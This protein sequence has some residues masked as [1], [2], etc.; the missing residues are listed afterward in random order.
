MTNP[1]DA[2]TLEKPLLALDRVT[3]DFSSDG[4]QVA[5]AL[6]EVSLSINK[7]ETLGVVGE[8]G[9][10]KSTLIRCATRLCDVT[11]GRV[12][13]NGTD[14]TDHHQSELVPLRKRMQIVFQDPY[15]SLNPRHRVGSIIGEP[16]VIHENAQGTELKDRVEE[17]MKLVGLDPAASDRY[18]S[19][20]SG[21]QR[22]R[23][24]IARA[25]ILKPE[26]VV[27]DEPVS[28]LD[29]SV[30]AQILNLL[31]DMQTEFGLTF[32]FVSHDLDVIRHMS[33][34]VAVMNKGRIVECQPTSELFAAPQNAY[35]KSLLGC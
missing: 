27:C 20:F 34:R 11:R 13:F 16:L 18:P 28:A 35:T 5:R 4:G 24:N 31:Q 26:F 15:G 29:V 21:G 1:I 9:A 32:L 8:T 2:P 3:K 14:I 17:A 6:D 30:Q 12:F 7:G 10:G 22:Q 25:M 23:I 33:T 19:D